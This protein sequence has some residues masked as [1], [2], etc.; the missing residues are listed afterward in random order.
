MDLQ[1]KVAFITNGQTADLI[2]VVAKT[3]P[4]EGARGISLIML[5]ANARESEKAF[6]RGRNLKKIGLKAQ[7]T[8]EL[9]FGD[10]LVP[11]ENLLG[12]QEGRGF[13]QLVEQLPQERLLIAAG[14]RR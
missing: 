10:L 13:I 7:D 4:P 11:A 8:S 1:D 2:C 3:D 6:S 14:I 9:F 12:P 5:E